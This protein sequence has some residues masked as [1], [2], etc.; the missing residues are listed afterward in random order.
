VT[1]VDCA[2][3]AAGLGLIARVTALLCARGAAFPEVMERTRSAIRD[4]RMFGA[5]ETLEY[6]A[7]SGRINSLLAGISDSLHV[8]PVFRL[9]NNQTG[10]VALVRTHSGVL[11]ALEKTAREMPGRLWVLVFHAEAGELAEQLGARL[12]EACDVVR[13]EIVALDPIIG[14]H[15]GPGV[16]GYAALPLVAGEMDGDRDE[17]GVPPIPAPAG[18]RPPSQPPDNA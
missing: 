17:L 9:S 10:R 2:T 8:R 13:L 5:L 15:T 1:V 4:V 6:V 16:V 14:T 12:G 7:R 18:R 3:A 11:S